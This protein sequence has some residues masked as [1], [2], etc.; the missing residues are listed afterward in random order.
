MKRVAPNLDFFLYRPALA[1]PPLCSWSDVDRLTL[2]QLLDM[3]EALNFKAAMSDKRR[4][5]T[6]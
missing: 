5:A 2:T 1:E 4:K 3:H 6:K